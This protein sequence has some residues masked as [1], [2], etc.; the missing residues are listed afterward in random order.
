MSRAE[1]P[2]R[3]RSM[4]AAMLLCLCLAFPSRAQAAE[5][6]RLNSADPAPLSRPGGTGINDRIV[7]EAY[8]RNGLPVRLVRL[9]AERALLNANEGIDDGIYVRIAGL[10]RV[11]PNLVM[12]PEPV[13]EFLFT[14][15]TK[16]PAMRVNGWDGLKPY[17]VGLVTGWKIV[18]A[19]TAGVRARTSVKNE[20]SLFALLDKGRVEVVVLDLL[21]GLEAARSRGYQGVRALSPPLERRNMHIYLN[22]R[23]ADLVPKLA[24][25]LREMKRDGTIER[26]TRAGLAGVGIA[27][28]AP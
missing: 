18:E 20:E 15:F 25:A 23:H 22:K 11:Y 19:H 13:G 5:P 2:C 14:A 12:V 16:D 8:R 1:S 17:H 9:T 26:L 28:E 4:L 21:T 6:L 10:E 3:R 24:A 27:Q 7:A